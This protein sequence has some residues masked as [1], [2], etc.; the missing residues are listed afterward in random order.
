MAGWYS[1]SQVI[2]PTLVRIEELLKVAGQTTRELSTAI[3]AWHELDE[4]A[5]NAVK[6]QVR[7]RARKSASQCVLH[8]RCG[9]QRT[10]RALQLQG[11]L[12]ALEGASEQQGARLQALS[13]G[14]EETRRATLTPAQRLQPEAV[15]VGGKQAAAK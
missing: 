4:P 15:G 7:L 5:Q 9:L 10:R 1:V 13:Q 2:Q 6:M 11:R 8:L 3:A 12:A 14:L